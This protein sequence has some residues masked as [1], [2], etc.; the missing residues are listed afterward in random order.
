MCT[1]QG[2]DDKEDE[3]EEEMPEEFK[4]LSPEE[5]QRKIKVPCVTCYCVFGSEEFS[6]LRSAWMMGFG[7]LVVLLVSGN[8]TRARASIQTYT[9][10]H[11]HTHTCACPPLGRS[12]AVRRIHRAVRARRPHG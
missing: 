6:Q 8:D 4:E 3:E 11:T 5:Q 10:T 1:H 7:T 2:D 9:H 12:G